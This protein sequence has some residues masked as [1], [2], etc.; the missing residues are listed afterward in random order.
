[1]RT[2]KPQKTFSEKISLWPFTRFFLLLWCLKVQSLFVLIARL[3]LD[4]PMDDESREKMMTKEKQRKGSYLDWTW[5]TLN[6]PGIIHGSSVQWMC[7]FA[8]SK[9]PFGFV[10]FLDYLISYTYWMGQ[11]GLGKHPDNKGNKKSTCLLNVNRRLM[12]TC[13]V[14]YII[15]TNN[16][17]WRVRESPHRME[18]KINSMSLS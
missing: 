18:G 4:M 9:C 11:L 2:N 14:C 6:N 12:S 10:E 7:H 3:N 5:W 15:W 16:K 8:I 13:F 17:N 1:M